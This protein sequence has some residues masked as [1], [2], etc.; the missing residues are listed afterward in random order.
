MV[1]VVDQNGEAYGNFAGGGGGGLME[2]SVSCLW[3]WLEDSMYLSKL[4]STSKR[5][6]FTV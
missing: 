2:M 1:K 5:V 3:K 4:N 6:N